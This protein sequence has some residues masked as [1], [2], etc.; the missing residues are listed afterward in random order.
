MSLSELRLK[1]SLLLIDPHGEREEIH[2]DGWKVSEVPPNDSCLLTSKQSSRAESS[3]L[4]L[5]GFCLG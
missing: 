1:D 5:A 3:G 4:T 2:R